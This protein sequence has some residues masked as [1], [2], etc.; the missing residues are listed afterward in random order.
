MFP[1]A[2]L[3]N[4]ILAMLSFGTATGILVHDTSVDKAA[5][6]ALASPQT[7]TSDHGALHADTHTHTHR[8]N[9]NS[10]VRSQTSNPRIQPRNSDEKKYTL[11]KK[12]SN[13][14]LGTEYHW[15]SL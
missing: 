2:L 3:L 9:F 15:P 12:S 1:A 6:V 4:P 14:V 10:F 11:V 8:I 5:V 13:G 7:T